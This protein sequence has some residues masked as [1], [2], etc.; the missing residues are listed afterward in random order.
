MKAAIY[1]S[2]EDKKLLEDSVELLLAPTLT[3]RLTKLVGKPIDKILEYLPNGVESQMQDLVE[4]ALSAAADA[5][6]WSL[7]N[8]KQEASPWWNKAYAVFSGGVGGFFGLTG[9]AV[10]LPISTT[11][12]MRAVADIARS[13]GFDLDKD[14]TKQ[15]CIQ[16]FALGGER[17]DDDESETA[18]YAMRIATAELISTQASKWLSILIEKVAA[19][20]GIVVTEKAAVQA[21]PVIGAAGGAVVNA[22]FTDFY[23]DIA[24]GHFTV[25][26]LEE[27]YGFDFVRNE[28]N[29]IAMKKRLA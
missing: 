28:F 11:I 27:K 10:E 19:R 18:Y 2:N 15:S 4:A 14:D 6:L 13:E 3:S 21:I 23:Q 22:M 1:L 17:D 9:M 5:A 12:M 8:K 24:R 7:E 20:F 29:E 26:K 25:K 16:V